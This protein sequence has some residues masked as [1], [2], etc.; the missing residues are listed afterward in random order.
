VKQF[1]REIKMVR[2]IKHSL[3]IIILPIVSVT[4]NS[5]FAESV[6]TKPDPNSDIDPANT[7]VIEGLKISLAPRKEV[8]IQ[9]EPYILNLKEYTEKNAKP[10]FGENEPVNLI[11]NVH[12]ISNEP[13][14]LGVSIPREVENVQMKTLV[15]FDDRQVDVNGIPC[16]IHVLEGLSARICDSGR[17]GT[18]LLISPGEKLT[19][20]IDIP[21]YTFNYDHVRSTGKFYIYSRFT[22]YK[23]TDTT[24]I[25][26]DGPASTFLLIDPNKVAIAA[27]TLKDALN[28]VKMDASQVRNAVSVISVNPLPQYD[29]LIIKA[30]QYDWP[31]KD[32][33]LPGQ[34]WF[35]ASQFISKEIYDVA[36]AEAKRDNSENS[37]PNSHFIFNHY[38]DCYFTIYRNR[39]YLRREDIL[40][41]IDNSKAQNLDYQ[42]T[43]LSL[44]ATRDDIPR[45]AEMCTNSLYRDTGDKDFPDSYRPKQAQIH[46][47]FFRYPDISKVCL[48]RLLQK[49]MVLVKTK[50][51][52]SRYGNGGLP[53]PLI[54]AE[55]LAE[56][57]DV[58]S[59]PIFESYANKPRGRTSDEM[60][61][62]APGFIAQIDGPEA[63]KALRGLETRSSSRGVTER[64]KLGDPVGIDKTI[65]LAL[66]VVPWQDDIGQARHYFQIVLNV[67][68]SRI[69]SIPS[70]NLDGTEIRNLWAK[71]R[72]EFVKDF[73]A[74]YGFDPDAP[75]PPEPNSK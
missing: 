28:G 56:L 74:K 41:I 53:D 69:S 75:T 54:V 47:A 67:M 8:F 68:K 66:S 46:D 14:Y 15:Q 9:N 42:L 1:V 61:S 21:H 33:F 29:E 48:R 64:A 16:Y 3:F 52:D 30:I 71:Y 60:Q 36:V 25:T 19:F 11:V 12:N 34:L 50:T 20:T 39:K 2:K 23:T 57:K 58:E 73:I 55:W 62:Q 7:C 31:V 35:A 65:G 63:M 22:V 51:W 45:L 32:R 44:V 17:K 10:I 37:D 26:S 40:S 70:G 13:R 49:E 18:P 5:L 24:P 43:L 72:P 59:I 38:G 4:F 6:N 27:A